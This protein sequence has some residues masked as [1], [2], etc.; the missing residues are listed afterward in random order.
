MF[1]NVCSSMA[2]IAIIVVAADNTRNGW[3]FFTYETSCCFMSFLR[4]KSY[5]L[6]PHRS[7]LVIILVLLLLFAYTWQRITRKRGE[8]IQI[9][10]IFDFVPIWLCLGGGSMAEISRKNNRHGFIP[11]Y[12]V[13]NPSLKHFLGE[14]PC[15][16]VIKAT[17][18]THAHTKKA[19]SELLEIK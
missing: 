18:H 16:V 6:V 3:R 14:D 4:I 17:T 2:V 1:L 11:D 8:S 13:V 15:S 12:I 10:F 7:R 19:G 9:S 5:A